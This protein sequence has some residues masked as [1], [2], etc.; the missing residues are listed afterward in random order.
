MAVLDSFL[1]RMTIPTLF[2][3]S[4][5]S[6]VIASIF[7][8]LSHFRNSKTRTTNFLRQCSQPKQALR[9]SYAL[10]Y[11]PSARTALGTSRQQVDLSSGRHQILPMRQ[12]YKISDP[13]T[14]VF[15]GFSVA[16]ILKLGDFPNYAELAGVP[17]PSP[18]PN[19]DI[20]LA[21]P[22][23]YRPIRWEYHQ[24]MC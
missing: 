22:R 12:S 24:T 1:T 13:S 17:L 10:I 15:S 18:L 21:R 7:A 8:L 5:M 4:F 20:N 6:M 9:P 11:P 23:P 3:V 16:E 2:V 14:Y 19:F